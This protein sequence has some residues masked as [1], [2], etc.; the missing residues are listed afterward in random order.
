MEPVSYLLRT[1]TCQARKGSTLAGI[2]EHYRGT[3]NSAA[4]VGSMTVIHNTLLH[5]CQNCQICV[6]PRR[7]LPNNK[8]P[9][10]L[11][12]L[13]DTNEPLVHHEIRAVH[14][15]AG[16]SSKLSHLLY[17]SVKTSALCVRTV[18]LDIC[19]QRTVFV[20]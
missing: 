12:S 20:K 11:A 18:A 10:C 13:L 9:M 4:S 16:Q 17:R 5:P 8:E 15:E 1:T 14:L 3:I 6:Q 2:T 7:K 19:K